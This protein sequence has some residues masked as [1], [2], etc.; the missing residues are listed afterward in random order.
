VARG[1]FT[2]QRR[3]WS[4][5]IG[6][7]SLAHQASARMK[8]WAAGPPLNQ[9][10]LARHGASALALGITNRSLGIKG[11]GNGLR[12]CQNRPGNVVVTGDRPPPGLAPSTSLPRTALDL[13]GNGKTLEFP[14]LESS[15]AAPGG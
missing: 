3:E 8:H 2:P 6:R 9:L 10:L 11:P 15:G 14:N 5:R 4:F 7:H 12:R 13:E 1:I